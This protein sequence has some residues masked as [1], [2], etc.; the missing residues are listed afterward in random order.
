MIISFKYCFAP[1]EFRHSK[2][3]TAQL[4]LRVSA[5]F[6]PRF[7]SLKNQKYIQYPFVF[8]AL[9]WGKNPV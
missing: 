6:L 2:G 8:Q 3:N 4:G 7:F 1:D 5:V 9:N